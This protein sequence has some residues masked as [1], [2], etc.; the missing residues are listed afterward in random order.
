MLDYQD[1]PNKELSAI[2]AWE[3]IET[4]D[5]DNNLPLILK[6]EKTSY[7]G[8]VTDIKKRKAIELY[9]MNKA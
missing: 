2:Y 9:A 4:L 5:L 3:K 6:K 7:Q 1:K 8:R